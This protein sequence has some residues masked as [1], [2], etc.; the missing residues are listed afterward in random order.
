MSG[1][2]MELAATDWG[3]T[4][5]V[6]FAVVFVIK[7]L[8]RKSEEASTEAPRKSAR[9]PVEAG[10]ERA[11]RLM[12]ALGLPV[13]GAPVPRVERAGP[14]AFP[15]RAKMAP[16]QP[17]GQ[18]APVVPPKNAPHHG[19]PVSV[20]PPV[21]PDGM[22]EAFGSAGKGGWNTVSSRVDAFAQEAPEQV[23]TGRSVSTAKFPVRRL[24]GNRGALREAMVLRE[25][26]G[27]PRGLQSPQE[28]SRVFGS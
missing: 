6:V 15:G 7:L 16:R 23:K 18:G 5:F 24:L 3:I 28:A 1:L 13:E 11:R 2:G 9:K 14:P 4:S 21:V 27:P 12:E 26:L 25:I 8:L 20:A 22:E 19:S 10:E 17:V